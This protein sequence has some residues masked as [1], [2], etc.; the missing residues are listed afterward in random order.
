MTKMDVSRYNAADVLPVPETASKYELPTT[1]NI[2]ETQ[3][4]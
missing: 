4:T 2:A 1:W 3:M